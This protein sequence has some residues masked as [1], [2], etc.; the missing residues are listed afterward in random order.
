[1]DNGGFSMNFRVVKTLLA[2][3]AFAAVAHAQLDTPFQVRYISNLT[4]DVAGLSD[5]INIT[6]TGASST[7]AFP[8]QNGNFCANVY[9]FSPDEQ[10]ISCC[11]CNVTPD[12]LV[13]LSAVNDLVSNTLTP[14][15]PT[16]IVV[17]LLSSAGPGGVASTASCVASASTVGTGANL[18]VPGLAAW[19]TSIHALPVTP[20]TPATTF[21]LTETPFTPSTLSAAELVR[22]TTLCGFIQGNGSGFGLCRA[23]RFGGLGAVSQ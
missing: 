23:C 9:T 11:A 19:A 22:I 2:A 16:S 15:H 1:M 12:G 3:A 13:S 17:K 4:T 10:L 20:G 6:N 8:T 18:I 5:V 21:G 14:G 7:V